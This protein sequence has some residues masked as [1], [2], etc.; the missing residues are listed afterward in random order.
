MPCRW[1]RSCVF[2]LLP[3][4]PETDG[5][6]YTRKDFLHGQNVYRAPLYR[7]WSRTPRIFSGILR[8]RTFTGGLGSC[9]PE[10]K[11]IGASVIPMSSG[12]TENRFWCM[13]SGSTV[14]CCTLLM[15]FIWRMPL[16]IPVSAWGIPTNRKSV[17]SVRKT[18]TEN[19]RHEIE[20]N[21]Y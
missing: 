17:R 18:W 14:L 2:M 15:H 3:E 21:W 11:N 19:M 6:Q 4:R 9:T 13:I 16:K 12:N 1:A 20:E 5:C 8:I 7:L 10:P